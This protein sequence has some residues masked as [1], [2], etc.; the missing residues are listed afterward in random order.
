MVNVGDLISPTMQLTTD[1]HA[2]SDPGPFTVPE[3]FYLDHADRIA[4]GH[5]P[6][7]HGGTARKHR[8]HPGRRQRLSA[9][10]ALRLRQPPGA[11]LDR[12]HQV[13]ALFPNPDRSC[14]PGITPRCAR[15]TQNI[16]NA[17]LI[18]QRV[19]QRNCRASTRSW[20]SSADNTAEV[21]NVTLGDIVGSLWIITSGPQPGE[22]VVV[23][24][25]QKCQQ[26]SP[27]T[28]RAL[29]DARTTSRQPT[30]RGAAPPGQS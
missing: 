7:P 25:I 6:I 26:G 1:L 20:S 15:V 18:P 28:P 11:N 3:Q 17:V 27:V 29:R 21:R 30:L 16:S 13:Y 9:Q 8:A 12:R 22:H 24:G 2:R 4:Q 14:A 10:G 5:P 19:R 23:E